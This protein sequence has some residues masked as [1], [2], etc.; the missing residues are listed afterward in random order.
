MLLTFIY[1]F[2]N[3]LKITFKVKTK[4]SFNIAYIQITWTI[5]FKIQNLKWFARVI[6]SGFGWTYISI[7]LLKKYCLDIGQQLK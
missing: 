3:S 7:A 5:T 6:L 2:T 1:I 4:A